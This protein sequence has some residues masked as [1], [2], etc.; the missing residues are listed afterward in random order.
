[1]LKLFVT[2][3]STFQASSSALGAAIHLPCVA[4]PHKGLDPPLD[5]IPIHMSA[6]CKHED[7]IR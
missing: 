3:H 6:F 1:V 2:P 5:I 7:F 4:P